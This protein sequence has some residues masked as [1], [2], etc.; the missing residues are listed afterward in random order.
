MNFRLE[1]RSAKNVPDLSDAFERV[2][3]EFT[4][5][6]DFD[7][8]NAKAKAYERYSFGWTDWRGLYG[9]PGA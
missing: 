9:S 2:A 6:N 1:Y 5:D 4:Q 8:E 3:N 7:T